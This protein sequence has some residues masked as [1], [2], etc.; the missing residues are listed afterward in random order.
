MNEMDFPSGDHVGCIPTKLSRAGSVL[1]IPAGDI[2]ANETYS[3]P[4]VFS[5]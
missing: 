5:T 2:A 1:F 3:M 4:G